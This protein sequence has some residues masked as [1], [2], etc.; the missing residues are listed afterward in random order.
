M[1]GDRE[2]GG[3]VVGSSWLLL[4][5]PRERFQGSA[6][7]QDPMPRVTELLK[8]KGELLEVPLG[9]SCEFS[10]GVVVRGL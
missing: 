8:T 3:H 4:R 1:I 5:D 6:G 10:P 9:A 7:A 2:A